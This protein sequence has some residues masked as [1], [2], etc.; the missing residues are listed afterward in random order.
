MLRPCPVDRTEL[1][2]PVPS[3]RR[4]DVVF[5]LRDEH[6]IV[7]LALVIEIQLS[8]DGRR[9]RSTRDILVSLCGR[10]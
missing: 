6:G 7:R 3:E 5:E 8:R 2:E 4:A 10:L 9:A 1:G